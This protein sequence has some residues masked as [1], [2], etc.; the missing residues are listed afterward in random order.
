FFAFR[1]LFHNF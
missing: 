1:R